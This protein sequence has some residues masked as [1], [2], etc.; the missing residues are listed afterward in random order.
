MAIP[1]AAPKSVQ[2]FAATL[3]KVYGASVFLGDYLRSGAN[4]KQ[5]VIPERK[6]KAFHELLPA[7]YRR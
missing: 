7:S 4:F 6:L 5:L 3:S 1:I 2:D